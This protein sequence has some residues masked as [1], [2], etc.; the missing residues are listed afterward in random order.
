M[1]GFTDVR[2]RADGN[3][4]CSVCGKQLGKDFADRVKAESPQHAE[5]LRKQTNASVR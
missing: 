4:F 3:Y 1:C 2:K 5:Q